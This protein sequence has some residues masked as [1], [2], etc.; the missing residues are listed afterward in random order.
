MDDEIFVIVITLI[1]IGGALALAGRVIRAVNQHLD[2]EA[3]LV[4]PPAAEASV[5]GGAIVNV[6][7]ELEG[8]RTQV[9]LLEERMDFTERLLAQTR[10]REL[11]PPGRESSRG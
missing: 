5:G 1:G 3:R 2:R 7:E 4:T 6:R 8:L 9:V 11:P 10:D